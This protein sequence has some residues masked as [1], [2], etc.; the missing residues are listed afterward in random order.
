M[1]GHENA[2][3]YHPCGTV[4]HGKILEVIHQIHFRCME[5]DNEIAVPHKTAHSMAS[6]AN[7]V[8][9]FYTRNKTQDDIFKSLK[10]VVDQRKENYL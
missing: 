10:W 2:T 4:D 3:Q 1:H 8:S 5:H 6:I 9:C 7:E